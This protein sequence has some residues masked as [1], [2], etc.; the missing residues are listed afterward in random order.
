MDL[1]TLENDYFLVRFYSKDDYEF[2]RDQGPWT[3][4][5]HYLVAKEWMPNID[6]ITDKTEKLIVWVRIPCLPIEY[7][8]FM[9]LKK[10]G[11]K[12]GKPI[13]VDHSTRIVA[14]G[15]FA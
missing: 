7:F 11:E 6:P 4:L 15:G 9:F 5:D 13:R 2:A 12:I 8:N 10:V 14:L 3:I 1:I